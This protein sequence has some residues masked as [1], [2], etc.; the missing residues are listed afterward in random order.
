MRV[1]ITGI[2]GFIGAELAHK[3]VEEGQEVYGFVRHVVGR[4]LKCLDDIK[5]KIKLI[6]C[7]TTDYFSVRN[8][9][10]KVGPEV[11]FHLAALSPVRLSFE[12]P[13]DYQKN[14]FLGTVNIVE[15]ILDLYGVEKVRLIVASTAEVYG[16]QNSMSPSTEDLRLEPSSPYAVAKASMDMYMRMLFYIYDFNGVLLRN[17]NTFGRKYDD[18][19]FTEYLITEM[20]KGN[21]IYIG[22]PDSVRDY[23]YVDDHVNSYLLAMKSPNAKGQVFNIAGGKGYTNK[24]WT[25]KI[26]EQIN[27]PLE[28]I[29]FGEYPPGYPSRPLK[30]DQPYLVLDASKAQRILGWRQTMSPEEGLRKTIDYW[31]SKINNSKKKEISEEAL[32]KIKEIIDSY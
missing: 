23:M 20:L 24:E 1:L 5:D 10:K 9:L 13:F 15:A 4:D 11:V 8:S 2:T 16:I 3:L 14:T 27:F 19:F 31:R 28:K 17:S 18:S 22:A 32:E 7:D 25:L 12:H 21:D 29:H 26:A 6:T 30:S